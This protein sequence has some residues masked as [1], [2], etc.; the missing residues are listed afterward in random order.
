MI[1][2][3][4][5]KKTAI[6]AGIAVFLLAVDRFL[7]IS[8]IN[9]LLDQP[10][11][12]IGNI[13]QLSFVKNYFIAFSIP[14]NNLVAITISSIIIIFFLVFTIYCIKKRKTLLIGF[15]FFIILGASSNLIDRIEY[16]YVIDYLDLNYFTVFN[17]ADAI[18][19]L[20]VAG[21]ILSQKNN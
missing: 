3:I 13:L 1:Y 4:S 9:S 5:N 7:K 12:Y 2:N 19:V 11:N 6:L 20:G 10:I 14:I 16:G 17:I 8:A 21:L 15:L 18:I